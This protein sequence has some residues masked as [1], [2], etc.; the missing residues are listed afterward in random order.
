MV[1]KTPNF[2]NYRVEIVI[3]LFGHVTDLHNFEL[4]MRVLNPYET[5][6][7]IARIGYLNFFNPLKPEG[8]WGFDLSRWDQRMMV[9]MMVL[10]ET[11]EPGENWSGMG[12]IRCGVFIIFFMLLVIT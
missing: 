9:K 6:C 8:S 4:V 1:D 3:L 2:G 5:S 11:H 10:L 7:V 12:G